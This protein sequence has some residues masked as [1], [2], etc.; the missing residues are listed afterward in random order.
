M[1]DELEA[2]VQHKALQIFQDPDQNFDIFQEYAVNVQTLSGSPANAMVFLAMLEAGDT[3]LTLN[4]NNGGHLSHMH[5]TS[6]WLKFFNLVNYDVTETQPNTFE[7]D[8]QDFEKKL[9]TY[10]PKLTILGAS[11]YPR[12]IPFARLTHLAHS[13]GSLVLA[14]IAHINGLVAGG[15]HPTPFQAGDQGADFVSMT[16]HKTFRGPRAAM[17]FTKKDYQKQINRTVFPGT[18]GGPHFN[19]IA[20]IGQACMEILGE[21]QYPDQRSFTEYTRQI[22]NNTKS[23]ENALKDNGLDIISPTENHLCLVRLPETSDSLAIQKKLESLGIITNRNVIP[24]DPKT[25]WKPSGLRLGTAALTSRGLTSAHS[26]QLG[27]LLSDT[28]FERQTE[29]QVQTQIK[30]ILETLSFYYTP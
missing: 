14:D 20:A 6:N 1:T 21:D 12:Q 2:M 8:E 24:F 23:L 18:S 7:I 22:I 25:A 15:Q 9:Q 3:V 27:Q 17:L 29:E 30:N 16:T 19:K 4:L 10:H 5:R 28:I 11:S 13:Y 26:Y